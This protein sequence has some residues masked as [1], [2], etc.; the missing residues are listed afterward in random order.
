MELNVLK[1]ESDFGRWD[2]CF[3]IKFF[4]NM[5]RSTNKIQLLG[6]LGRSPDIKTFQNGSKLARLT[7]STHSCYKDEKGKKI[8]QRHWH[9]VVV[10][11]RLAEVVERDI[12]RGSELTVE[13]E[14][15]SRSYTDRTGASRLVTEVEASEVLPGLSCDRKIP[16]SGSG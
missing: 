6:N 15:I 16:A 2:I 12:P 4:G 11:G 5:K 14:L 7:M 13:G 3:R 1:P 10:H 8:T 9:T